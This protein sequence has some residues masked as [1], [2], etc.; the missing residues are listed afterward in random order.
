MEFVTGRTS[1]SLLLIW[2][3]NDELTRMVSLSSS[4]DWSLTSTSSGLNLDNTR[5]DRLKCIQ[6][7]DRYTPQY[8]FYVVRIRHKTPRLPHLPASS[9]SPERESRAHMNIAPSFDKEED[10]ELH[11]TMIFFEPGCIPCSLFISHGQIVSK[12]SLTLYT[13]N[14]TA[15]SLSSVRSNSTGSALVLP[16][17]FAFPFP[18]APP[19]N[20][21]INLPD[22]LIYAANFSPKGL[23]EVASAST[24]SS[25][26]ILDL[27]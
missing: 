22:G 12:T 26:V 21:E 2:W 25:K 20:D 24:V 16:F 15:S 27:V 8:P 6:Q 19:V 10:E 18:L 1:V 7:N 14:T 4:V 11:T 17:P 5:M 23:K 9:A 3:E 13:S